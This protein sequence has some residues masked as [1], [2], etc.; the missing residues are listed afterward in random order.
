MTEKGVWLVSSLAP[1][2]CVDCLVGLLVV[3]RPGNM[4][5]YLRVGS[6]QT[7]VPAAILR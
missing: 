1:P 2:I 7:S 3:L 4:L 5:V 6:A